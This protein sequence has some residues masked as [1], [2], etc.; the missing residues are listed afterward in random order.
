MNEGIEKI[1]PRRI[2][3][4]AT[5][6]SDTQ[7]CSQQTRINEF[8][9]SLVSF[10]LCLGSNIK[11]F[12]EA[13]S[14]ISQLRSHQVVLTDLCLQ[15]KTTK[16]LNTSLALCSSASALMSPLFNVVPLIVSLFIIFM[17]FLACPHG[18]EACAKGDDVEKHYFQ[19]VQRQRRL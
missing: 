3:N 15:T 12:S 4:R 1:P 8:F 19:V 13:Q 14:R 5:V 11:Y 6:L 10:L 18:D 16:H 7:Y 2:I 17:S 9:S